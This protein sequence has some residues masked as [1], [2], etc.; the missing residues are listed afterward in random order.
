MIDEIDS[1][2]W[3]AKKSCH[4]KPARITSKD[5]RNRTHQDATRLVDAEIP[6]RGLGNIFTG[7]SP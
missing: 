6:P 5:L 2:H 1:Y 3:S 4:Y 7:Q